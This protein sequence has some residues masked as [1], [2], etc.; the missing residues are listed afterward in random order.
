M[1][2]KLQAIVPARTLVEL[3][4]ICSGSVAE[5]MTIVPTDNQVLFEVGGVSLISRLIDGQ[6]PNYRQLLPENF[7]YEVEV[8][9]DEF[10]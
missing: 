6:F 5:T 10:I 2:E 3:S 9:R 1:N 8:E 7:E 4:R